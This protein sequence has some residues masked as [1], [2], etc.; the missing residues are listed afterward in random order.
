MKI[1][2]LSH[3]AYS[4]GTILEVSPEDAAAWVRRG[5]GEFVKDEPE[6]AEM[7]PPENAMLRKPKPRK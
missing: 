7:A 1:R 6:T 4:K 3:P 2:V 5:R